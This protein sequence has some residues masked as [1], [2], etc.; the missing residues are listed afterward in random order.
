MIDH[1]RIR[2]PTC[3]NCG[4]ET[5]FYDS[6]VPV[7]LECSKAHDIK[8]SKPAAGSETV[9]ILVNEIVEATARTN[10]A[11]RDFFEVMDQMPTAFPHPDGSQRIHN[12]ARELSMARKYLTWTH[13]RLDD[14]LKTGV[15]PDD[16]KRSR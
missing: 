5:E 3:S 11:V 15:V 2:M 7:C 16:L 13:T 9:H 8:A 14:F 10:K 1:G 6:S 4:A 12:A